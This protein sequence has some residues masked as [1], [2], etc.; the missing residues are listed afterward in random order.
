MIYDTATLIN[1][2]I[3][4]TQARLFAPWIQPMFE[5]FGIDTVEEQAALIANARHESMNFTALEEGLSYSSVARMK[6]VFRRLRQLPDSVLQPYVR[7]PKA[8]GSFVYANINGNGNE[9]SG[10]GYIYRG[11]GLPQLTGRGNYADAAMDCGYPYVEQPKLVAEPQ[12]ATLVFGSY[13][14][15]RGL[16]HALRDRGINGVSERIVG[17]GRTNVERMALYEEVLDALA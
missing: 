2:G 15:R 7:N 10:D 17:D 11:R 14:V 1:C 5:H 6:I 13:W 12:H 16:G 3:G 8:F 4:P 9:A